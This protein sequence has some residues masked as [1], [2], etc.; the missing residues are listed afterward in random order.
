ML[1]NK[2]FAIVFY[3]GTLCNAEKN[4]KSVTK[5]KITA[6]YLKTCKTTGYRK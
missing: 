3:G 2:I 1:M 5:Q 4:K 6:S